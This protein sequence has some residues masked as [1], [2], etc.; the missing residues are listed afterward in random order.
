MEAMVDDAAL[1]PPPPARRSWRERFTEGLFTKTSLLVAALTLLSAAGAGFG[2]YWLEL[3]PKIDAA[4]KRF[5]TVRAVMRLYGLQKTHK[6]RFGTYANDLNALLR[7]MPNGESFKSEVAS[8]LDLNTLTVVGN[9]E[10]FKI[11][12]NMLDAERTL[13]KIRGPIPEGPPDE[14]ED[15]EFGAESGMGEGDGAPIELEEPAPN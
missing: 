4:D 13:V 9:A 6:Q 12:A 2:Y 10:Q 5:V 15:P 1:P 14:E 8:S 11:E 3:K 7:L